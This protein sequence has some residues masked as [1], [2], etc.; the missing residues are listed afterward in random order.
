MKLHAVIRTRHSGGYVASHEFVAMFEDLTKAETVARLLTERAEQGRNALSSESVT[1]AVGEI[2]PNV[3]EWD[4]AIYSP[5]PL[6]PDTWYPNMDAMDLT[7][8]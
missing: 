6:S 1:F 5:G 2:V 8:S 3:G 7:N 4:E